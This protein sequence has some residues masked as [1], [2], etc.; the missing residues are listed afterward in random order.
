MADRYALDPLDVGSQY[1][2]AAGVG[3]DD[4]DS[5]GATRWPPGGPTAPVAPR[6]GSA[7][8]AAETQIHLLDYVRVVYKRRWLAGA[9][10]LIVFLGAVIYTFTATPIF[11]ARVQLLIEAENQNVVSFKEVIEQEKAT[12][13]YYQTQYRILQSRSLARRTIDRLALWS[14]PYL[15]PSKAA[16]Q[17]TIRSV[18]TLPI[19]YVWQLFKPAGQNEPAADDET[20]SQSA[21]IDQFLL[22]LTV[23]P[24]RNSRLMD[25]RY[26]S[27][28]SAFAAQLVNGLSQNRASSSNTTRPEKPRTGSASKWASSAS[29][30]KRARRRC[31]A[32]ANR[33]TRSRSKISKTSLSRSWPISIAR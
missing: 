1:L 2:H 28:D 6:P 21:V 26:R 8:P 3:S 29:R 22:G 7:G 16:P 32:I 19:A 11:D 27:S 15:D 33:P 25:L 18:I 9:A 31:N 20:A 13:D 5:R 10:F 14:H 30:S 4:T 12:N 23:S 24:I 17:T